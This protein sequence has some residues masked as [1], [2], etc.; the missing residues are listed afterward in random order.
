MITGCPSIS[1]FLEQA[2]Q[3]LWFDHLLRQADLNHA[4]TSTLAATSVFQLFAVQLGASGLLGLLKG[5]S[6]MLTAPPPP[7]PKPKEH[8]WVLNSVKHRCTRCDVRPS[9][10]EA[11]TSTP[12]F[13]AARRA[14]WL[15]Q[16]AKF[17]EVL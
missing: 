8:A 14:T 15:T 5:F 10:F 3:A 11:S 4:R 1:G 12:A 7:P 17:C 16:F 13:A 6:K 9:A 2:L